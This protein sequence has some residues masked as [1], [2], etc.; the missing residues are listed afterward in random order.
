MNQVVG[1]KVLHLP[2]ISTA[3]VEPEGS[4]PKWHQTVRFNVIMQI[5]ATII[6]VAL[7][8]P[9]VNMR[10]R[11]SVDFGARD[12]YYQLP[13]K[14]D[15]IIAYIIVIIYYLIAILGVHVKW[16]VFYLKSQGINI[17]DKSY[18]RMLL[19][20]GFFIAASSVFFILISNA[21]NPN[22]TPQGFNDWVKEKYQLSEVQPLNG[23][24]ILYGKNLDNENVRLFVSID[25]RQARVFRTLDEL[26]QFTK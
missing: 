20:T 21:P 17:P 9:A 13:E 8:I 3:D 14:H 7:Y 12:G 6:M 10:N 11:L 5:L 4:N 16:Q 24:D 26:D 25:Q 1:G 18:R 2:G 22:P 15:E 23:K 19:S